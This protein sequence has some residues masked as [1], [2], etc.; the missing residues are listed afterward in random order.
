MSCT[1]LKNCIGEREKGGQL[2]CPLS[3]AYPKQVQKINRQKSYPLFYLSLTQL[4]DLTDLL[5][6]IH[7]G[8]DF[9]MHAYAH[10]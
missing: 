4:L 6:Q 1:N 7:P 5:I 9:C 3:L 10:H 8:F 2:F